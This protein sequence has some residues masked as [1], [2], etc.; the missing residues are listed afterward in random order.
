MELPL[1]FAFFF[2]PKNIKELQY[3]FFRD[4]FTFPICLDFNDEFN[5]INKFPTKEEFHTFLLDSQNCV[6]AIGSP[7]QNP[8]VKIL[9]YSIVRPNGK[10]KESKSIVQ[11]DKTEHDFG[12]VSLGK[13][14]KC[15]FIMTNISQESLEIKTILTSCECTTVECDNFLLSSGESA[16]ITVFFKEI[17]VLG[18][19]YRTISIF[20]KGDDIPII[21]SIKGRIV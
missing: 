18:D 19:F 17:S 10:G 3:K 5:N 8:Q 13:Q 2:H 1:S 11:M 4:N 15:D 21:L 12:V 16:R 7:I 14:Y 9:Y 20:Y 6:V